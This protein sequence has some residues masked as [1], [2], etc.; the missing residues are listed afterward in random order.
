MP[1]SRRGVSCAS[2]PPSP[3]TT[4]CTTEAVRPL[5]QA[6]T[7]LVVET[8]LII[9]TSSRLSLQIMYLCF[10]CFRKRYFFLEFFQPPPIW[11]PFSS[12]FLLGMQCGCICDSFW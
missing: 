7:S 4:A 2:R 10:L 11:M 8:H 1:H 12:I 3:E 5:A 9:V 6:V